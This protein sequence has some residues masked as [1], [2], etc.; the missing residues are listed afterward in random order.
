MLNMRLKMK[1]SH[2]ILNSLNLI[3]ASVL[4][5][6]GCTGNLKKVDDA[7]AFVGT[8]SISEVEQVKWGNDSGT[9]TDTGTLFISKISA[10]RVQATGY[11]RTQGEVVGNI[12]YFEATHTEDSEGYID[13]VY[14]PGIL[15]GNV[16]TITGSSTGKLRYNGVLYPWSRTAQITGIKQY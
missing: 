9:L 10:T 11:F 4:L 3:A 14:G 8:Y 16:L 15:T 7:D 6:T 2:R 12:V 5:F 13:S 1:T